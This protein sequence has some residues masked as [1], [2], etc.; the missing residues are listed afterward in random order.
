MYPPHA[1]CSERI[2]LRPFEFEDAPALQAGLNQ[3]ELTGRRY[4]HWAFSNDLPLSK[5]QVEGL[6]E[7]WSEE[8]KATH[9]AV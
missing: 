2:R 7:K 4:I 3:A 9:L 1:F 5:K 6:L 8:E